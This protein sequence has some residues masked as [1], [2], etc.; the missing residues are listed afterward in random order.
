MREWEF[1]LILDRTLTE[2]DLQPFAELGEDLGDPA[3]GSLGSTFGGAEPS[4]CHCFTPGVSLLDAVIRAASAIYE[5][6]GARTV[7]IEVDEEHRSD[8][9]GLAT[10][11]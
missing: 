2:A 9:D 7:R 3:N 5:H 4:E 6:L 8:L 11:A 10:V 1:T